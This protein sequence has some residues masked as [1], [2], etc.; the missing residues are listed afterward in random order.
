M[1]R[2]QLKL[3]VNGRIKVEIAMARRVIACPHT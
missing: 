2:R 1:A 3:L